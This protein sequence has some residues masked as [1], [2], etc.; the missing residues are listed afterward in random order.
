MT[1]LSLRRG[2][3]E[4]LWKKRIVLLTVHQGRAILI[5]LCDWL[6]QEAG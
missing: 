2:G 4:N 6:R 1:I 3:G 5:L